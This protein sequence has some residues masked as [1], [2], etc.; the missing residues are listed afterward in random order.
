MASGTHF[1]CTS[2]LPEKMRKMCVCLLGHATCQLLQLAL[3]FPLFL[4]PRSRDGSSQPGSGMLAEAFKRGAT[5]ELSDVNKFASENKT[6]AVPGGGLTEFLCM[7]VKELR[8]WQKLSQ[9]EFS[10]FGKL[11]PLQSHLYS[12]LGQSK[13]K[14]EKVFDCSRDWFG[15]ARVVQTGVHICSVSLCSGPPSQASGF[16]PFLL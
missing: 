3:A 14:R 7:W 1:K 11:V 5:V 6:Y 8:T 4:M 10:C 15:F 2:G 12:L 13:W 9:S 16:L